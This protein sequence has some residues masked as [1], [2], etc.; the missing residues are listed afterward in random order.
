MQFPNRSVVHAADAQGLYQAVD[1]VG[2]NVQFVGLVLVQRKVRNRDQRVAGDGGVQRRRAREEPLKVERVVLHVDQVAGALVEP[3]DLARFL[4]PQLADASQ[5]ALALLGLLLQRV[6]RGV[7]RD[8]FGNLLAKPLNQRILGHVDP[9][10][11][12][13]HF[14]PGTRNG[15]AEVGPMH[16]IDRGALVLDLLL[17]LIQRGD[18]RL[19]GAVTGH[20][21]EPLD[22]NRIARAA[23]HIVNV[24]RDL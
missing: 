23:V 13:G 10:P 12:L 19:R 1:A 8:G 4:V 2:E 15:V 24:F 16:V 14:L 17:D 9:S 3:D 21:V 22:G 7:E 5:V 18:F 11:N 6:G 20:A